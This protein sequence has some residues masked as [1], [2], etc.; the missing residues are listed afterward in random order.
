M[1]SPALSRTA[2]LTV[3]LLW[4]VAMLNYLDR[5]A[6]AQ[7]CQ[8]KHAA[9]LHM[10]CADCHAGAAMSKDTADILL[11]SQKLCAECHRPRDYTKVET[12]PTKRIAPTFGQFTPDAASKQRKEGG[13]FDSCLGCHKYH[14]PAAEIEI[15][16]SLAK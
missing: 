4:P 14:V 12:D 7:V 11:P 6:A 10:D 16:K 9:H 13:V 1:K 8:R 5:A 2:W 15:A 3:A